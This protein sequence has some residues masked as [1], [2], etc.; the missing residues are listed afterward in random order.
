MKLI[1]VLVFLL[2]LM[3]AM[4]NAVYALPL[5]QSEAH[6]MS[7]I[8]SKSFSLCNEYITY[9]ETSKCRKQNY[10]LDSN[11][12]KFTLSNEAWRQSMYF[13]TGIDKSLVKYYQLAVNNKKFGYYENNRIVPVDELVVTTGSQKCTTFPNLKNELLFVMNIPSGLVTAVPVRGR[14]VIALE[15]ISSPKTNCDV[16]TTHAGIALGYK[17]Y[18]NPKAYDEDIENAY[19]GIT[20]AKVS[21]YT[22]GTIEYSDDWKIAENLTNCSGH[23][24]PDITTFV[25][26]LYY[27]NDNYDELE[28]LSKKEEDNVWE[29]VKLYNKLL[30]SNTTA[31][32]VQ[33]QFKSNLKIR[34]QPTDKS[35]ASWCFSYSLPR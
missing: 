21:V 32:S 23:F 22:A 33:S 24:Q 14:S 10:Q 27:L 29:D 16:F 6:S 18:K 28:L 25:N 3:C 1:N 9:D 11:L 4:C 19:L 2:C 7:M 8:I 13:R 34:T 26:F 17:Y 35:I 5:G 15:T 20:D 12:K 31:E 30:G